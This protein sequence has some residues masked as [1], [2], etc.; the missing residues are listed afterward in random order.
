MELGLIKIL[1]LINKNQPI[2]ISTLFSSFNLIFKSFNASILF[3]FI[4]FLVIL[5]GL[6]IILISCEIDGFFLSL[7]NLIDLSAPIPTIT[8]D[9]KL[10]DIQIHNEPLFILGVLVFIINII[11]AAI[12]LQFYQYF[13]VDEECGAFQS[14]KRSF[15]MTDNKMNILVQFILSIL[16]INFLGLLCFGVGILFTVPFSLLAM[17]KLYLSLK[18]QAI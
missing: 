10:F 3:S 13:I 4:I 5:P 1:L 14:L 16:L 2:T 11:W 15:I 8:F 7:F 18:R 17:T 12:R 6:L 9:S